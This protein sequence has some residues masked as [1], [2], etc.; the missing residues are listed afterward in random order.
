MRTD[1]ASGRYQ[2][3]Q[4]IIDLASDLLNDLE[5]TNTIE[6]VIDICVI[7][8]NNWQM[9]GSTKPNCEPYKVTKI[10]DYSGNKYNKMELDTYNDKALLTLLS[11]RNKDKTQIQTIKDDSVDM[12]DTDYRNM[13]T[14]HKMR[15]QK[16]T[17]LTK[18]KKSPSKININE[19][20][21]SV[22]GGTIRD[23]IW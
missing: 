20:T 1:L 14:D 19:S 9:Y 22:S 3:V 4:Q 6:D 5:I 23:G 21:S 7:E 16:K 12:M 2:Q 11:I 18:K 8:K 10:Y 13:P 17:V 15:K